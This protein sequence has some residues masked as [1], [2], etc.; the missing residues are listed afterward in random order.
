MTYA[1]QKLRVLTHPKQKSV[2][3]REWSL[4]TG[5]RGVVRRREGG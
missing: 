4:I 1:V 5:G 2:R 3:L